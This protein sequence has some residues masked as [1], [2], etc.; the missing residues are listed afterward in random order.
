MNVL[1]YFEGPPANITGSKFITGTVFLHPYYL[2]WIA[3]LAGGPLLLLPILSLMLSTLLL[4]NSSHIFPYTILC[5]SCIMT[6][7]HTSISCLMDSTLLQ[8]GTATTRLVT[9]VPRGVYLN[10]IRIFFSVHYNHI[11]QLIIVP[12]RNL[13][14][15]QYPALPWLLLPKKLCLEFSKGGTIDLYMK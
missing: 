7:W 6:V 2:L 11:V 12:K 5:L 4:M 15:S 13:W 14:T 8:I 10:P 9:C 3:P 1:T